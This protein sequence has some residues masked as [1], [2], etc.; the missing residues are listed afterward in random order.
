MFF[1]AERRNG[2]FFVDEYENNQFH[3]FKRTVA[4]FPTKKLARKIAEEM[5]DLVNAFTGKEL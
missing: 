1:H 3:S 5:N 4:K 2:S